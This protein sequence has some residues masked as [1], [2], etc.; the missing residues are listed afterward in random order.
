MFNFL[1]NVIVFDGFINAISFFKSYIS[2]K[3]NTPLIKSGQENYKE[4]INKANIYNLPSIERYIMYGGVSLIYLGIYNII[5]S[6]VYIDQD[7][8]N[9]IFS[10]VLSIPNIQ[11][12]IF[13]DT[14]ISR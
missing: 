1:G 13:N 4:I 12:I 10:I 3:L 14:R 2:F 7:V 11:N 6:F 5:N 8:I 9:Y